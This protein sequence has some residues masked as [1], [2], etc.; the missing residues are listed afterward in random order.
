MPECGSEKAIAARTA[1]YSAEP[2]SMISASW[3]A[4]AERCW[5]M[6]AAATTRPA[7]AAHCHWA[8]GITAKTIQGRKVRR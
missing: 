6:T 2:I 3:A 7:R 1:K 8:D 5:R 4:P